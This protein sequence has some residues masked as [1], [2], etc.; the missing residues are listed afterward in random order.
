MA[1]IIAVACLLCCRIA[2]HCHC[3]GSV[4]VTLMMEMLELLAVDC[5]LAFV[6]NGRFYNSISVTN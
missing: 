4:M 3:N 5:W 6:F 2:V 1:F